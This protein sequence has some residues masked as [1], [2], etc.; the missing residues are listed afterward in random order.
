MQALYHLSVFQCCKHGAVL[1]SMPNVMIWAKFQLA[2]TVFDKVTLLGHVFISGQACMYCLTQI[3]WTFQ[4]AL[5]EMPPG[6]T[7]VRI[8]ARCTRARIPPMLAHILTFPLQQKSLGYHLVAS[9]R[10]ISSYK[11]H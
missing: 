7:V 1:F 5:A 4:E 2:S 10:I 11:C 6:R 8:T 3:T 9:L